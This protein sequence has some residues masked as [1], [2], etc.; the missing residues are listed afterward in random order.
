MVE[1]YRR[2]LHTQGLIL[3]YLGGVFRLY[4]GY[5][6]DYAIA[7]LLSLLR[8]RSFKTKDGGGPNAKVTTLLNCPHPPRRIFSM[9]I[10][11]SCAVGKD[12]EHSKS[13][14]H[15]PTDYENIVL[16]TSYCIICLEY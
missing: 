9:A 1:C 2:W 12:A 13:R 11:N 8:R 10:T 7:V 15:N 4:S 14:A 5:V 3:K 6:E 16:R